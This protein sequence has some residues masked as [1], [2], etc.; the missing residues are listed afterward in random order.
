[1]LLE[2][3]TI[4]H[5]QGGRKM[6]TNEEKAKII[7]NRIQNINFHISSISKGILD[8]PEEGPGKPPRAETLASLELEKQLMEQLL[9]DL[10]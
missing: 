6:L 4:L 9:Q 8:Y 10:A 2:V 3:L 5:I 1:M 7:Q